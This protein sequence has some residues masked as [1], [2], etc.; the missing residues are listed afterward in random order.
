[1][2]ILSWHSPIGWAIFLVAV[3]LTTFLLSMAIKVLA[4]LPPVPGVTTQKKK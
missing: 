2:Q 4:T 1:M 3:G